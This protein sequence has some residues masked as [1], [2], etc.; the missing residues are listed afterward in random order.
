MIKAVFF[1]LDGTLHDRDTTVGSLLE[2]QY[3]AFAT[4]L[5]TRAQR[6]VLDGA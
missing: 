5:L 4:D 6:A 2:E 1:D 3:G